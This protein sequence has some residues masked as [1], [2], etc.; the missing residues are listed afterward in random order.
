VIGGRVFLGETVDGPRAL[1]VVLALAGAFLVLGGPA[2]LDGGLAWADVLALTC[3]I[4]FAG[5]NL[6]FRAR[7]SL[8]VPAK[9]TAMLAGCFVL[10]VLAA[11]VTAPATPSPD[12]AAWAAA[13]GLGWVLVATVGT[14][15]G[16]TQL[17]AARAAVIIILE[18][19][20]AVLSAVLIGG[21][22]L[23]GA[24]L[25]GCGLILA[26]AWLEGRRG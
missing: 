6:V 24:K 5:N 1:A 9:V 10:A 21:E 13:Y 15:W 20:V 25:L 12:A 19:V 8:P 23:T 7:Q 4:S 18:L 16:V 11:A 3:G 22:S 14:Q 2:T 26:A 17:E